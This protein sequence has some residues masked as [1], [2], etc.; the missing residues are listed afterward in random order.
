MAQR[1]VAF[2]LCLGFDSE[3][4][5]RYG[6]ESRLW[7]WF[8]CYFADA[9]SAFFDAL[10]CFVDFVECI[11]VR[12]Q[13]TER[14]I[15]V[16][17]VGACICHVEAETVDFLG[18]FFGAALHLLEQAFAQVKKTFIVFHPLWFDIGKRVSCLP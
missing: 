11:L 5:P 12:G 14:K 6:I 8:A 3:P 7:D 17:V 9:V 1:S 16:E 18:R 15:A 4:G 13:Q 10:E 2:K